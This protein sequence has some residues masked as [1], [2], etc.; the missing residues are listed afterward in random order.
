MCLRQ[1]LWWHQTFWDL[2][3]VLQNLYIRKQVRRFWQS[4]RQISK[5]VCQR[6]RRPQTVLPSL[7]WPNCLEHVNS[8]PSPTPAVAT[9]REGK[10][11]T[12]WTFQAATIVVQV[13]K[14]RL[15]FFSLKFQVWVFLVLR[16]PFFKTQHF[17]PIVHL[18]MW[19]LWSTSS[20]PLLPGPLWSRVLSSDRVQCGLKRIVWHLNCGQTN[21]WCWIVTITVT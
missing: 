2:R 4:W 15:L 6:S 16:T 13:N 8:Q 21:V 18:E 3:F 14:K 19:E 17:G 11:I 7:L 5:Q 10:N 20:L 9:R 12:K 1:F